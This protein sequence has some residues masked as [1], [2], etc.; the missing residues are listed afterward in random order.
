MEIKDEIMKTSQNPRRKG[1]D[2]PVEDNK[3]KLS[4]T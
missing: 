2:T 3:T 4:F 1:L